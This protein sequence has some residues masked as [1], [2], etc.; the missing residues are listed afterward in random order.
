MMG[1]IYHKS[2]HCKVG[3]DAE[4]Q[5]VTIEWYGTP[6]Q[7]EFR[8]ACMKAIDALQDYKTSK[9]LTNNAQAGV[10]STQ[11]QRWLNAVWLPQAYK[12]GYRVSATVVSQDPFVRYAVKSIASQR[13]PEKFTAKTFETEAEAREWLKSL[14]P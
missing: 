2:K 3:Y 4:I 6:V 13:D 7:E 11:D 5:S 14:E 9:V 10:F 8:G 1:D 12:A